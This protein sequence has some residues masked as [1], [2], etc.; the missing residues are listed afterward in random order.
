MRGFEESNFLQQVSLVTE[1]NTGTSSQKLGHDN[2]RED[3]RSKAAHKQNLQKVAERMQIRATNIVA[4]ELFFE[5][6]LFSLRPFY[7]L[8][9]EKEKERARP[10][11]Q[12]RR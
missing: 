4:V 11:V 1:K 2:L 10:S 8:V 12:T 6:L 3:N 7:H 9:D 5:A